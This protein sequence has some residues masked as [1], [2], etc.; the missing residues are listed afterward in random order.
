MLKNCV[1]I[2]ET[3][4]LRKYNNQS[5]VHHGTEREKRRRRKMP[6]DLSCLNGLDELII[7]III[8]SL[9]QED[10]IFG[11]NASLTYGPQLQ[12]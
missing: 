6:S 2:N 1:S 4:L 8:I 9:F 11:T 10:N 12:R 5:T 3:G 7:I